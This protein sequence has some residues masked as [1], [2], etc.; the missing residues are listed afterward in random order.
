MKTVTYK[1]YN[2]NELS[3]KAKQN[4]IDKW[5]ESED[6]PMLSEDLT[7]SCGALLKDKKI[8]YA[9][10]KLYFSLSSCQGDGLCFVGEFQW[11]KYYIKITHNYRYYFAKSTEIML[12]DEEGEECCDKKAI[13]R[14]T[15]I[16]LDICGKLKKEGYGV[17]DY[18]MDFDEFQ[19]LCESNEYTFTDDGVMD[20]Q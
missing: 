5:Y 3:D 11:N 17:L 2:F 9:D 4:A 6:F 15:K 20:N 16:Y 18:R 19:E 7:E 10:L 12:M 13:D 14:F 1:V 8:T